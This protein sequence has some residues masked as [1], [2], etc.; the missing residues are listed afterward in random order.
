MKNEEWPG[1][2]PECGK[3]NIALEFK[4]V[5]EDPDCGKK[6]VEEWNRD[7][8]TQPMGPIGTWSATDVDWTF[9]YDYG[10]TD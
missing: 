9:D 5:C 3:R 4:V 7:E 8:T 6:L 1:K 2:C 10:D